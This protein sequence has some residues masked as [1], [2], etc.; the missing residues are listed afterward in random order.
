MAVPQ[1]IKNRTSLVVQWLRIRLPVQGAQVRSLVGEVRSH[2]QSSVAKRKK[3]KRDTPRPVMIYNHCSPEIIVS[4]PWQ[5]DGEDI[6][7]I[8]CSYLYLLI[9]CMSLLQKQ[10]FWNI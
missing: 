9:T 2:M 3:K 7:P 4:K 10:E 6:P 5:P 8:F 1:K